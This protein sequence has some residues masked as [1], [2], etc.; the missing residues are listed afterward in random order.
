MLFIYCEYILYRYVK[1]TAAI[2]FADFQGKYSDV[3]GG[4]PVKGSV[5]D[6]WTFPSFAILSFSVVGRF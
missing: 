3:A 1:E 2:G 5:G 4:L 6:E